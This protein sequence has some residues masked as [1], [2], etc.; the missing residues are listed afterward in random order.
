MKRFDSYLKSIVIAFVA[1]MSFSTLSAQDAFY[2][3]CNDGNF[4]GFFFDRVQRMGVSKLDL[5]GIE[6]E[7]YVV[8]EIQTADSLYRIPLAAIDS[9][10]FQQPEIRYNSDLRHMDE[11]GMSD[12]VTKV[13]G[14]TLTFTNLPSNMRPAVGNVLVGFDEDVFGDSGFG[15]K[16]TRV[17]PQGSTLIVE[18]ERLTDF[19]DIFDQFISVEEVGKDDEGNVRRRLAGFTPDGRLR[20]NNRHPKWDGNYGLSIVDWGGRLQYEHKPND[21]TSISVGV[22][23]GIN[24]GARLVY[25]I[26]ALI[27]RRF[28]VKAVFSEEFSVGVSLQASIGGTLE[29]PIPMPAG[30]NVKI[31][32]PAA[33]PMFQV[34]P[35]PEGFLRA[36]GQFAF[37]LALPKFKKGASQ[38][39][40]ID[41]KASPV[42]D[43]FWEDKDY[44]TADADESWFKQIEAGLTLNGFVQ[45]GVKQNF[46]FETNDWVEDIF[47]A[48][49]GCEVYC[50]PKIEA[51]VNL[52]VDGLLKNGAYG[53]MKDSY[54]EYSKFSLDRELKTK[55][56]TFADH[57][58]SMNEKTFWSDTRKFLTSRWSLFPNF[59]ATTVDYNKDTNLL[60]VTVRPRGQVFWRSW[61]GVGIDDMNGK[62]IQTV[63]NEQQSYDMGNTFNSF[64]AQF[65]DLEPGQYKVQPV[66]RS[67][68]VD[69][70]TYN[71]TTI[72][73]PVIFKNE[74]DSMELD[75]KK[76]N[77]TVKFYTNAK[78]VELVNAFGF[79]P[80]SS[81][82]NTYMIGP[83]AEVRLLTSAI[84]VDFVEN[85]SML[86]NE[87]RIVL[88]GT[89]EAEDV[90]AYDTICFVQDAS[91]LPEYMDI[92]YGIHLYYQ[93]I[94]QRSDYDSDYF[95]PLRFHSADFGIREDVSY[96]NPIFKITCKRERVGYK[97]YRFTW[98]DDQVGH[99]YRSG[100]TG[101]YDN[102][103]WDG[104]M[105]IK[106]H[107]VADIYEDKDS[108]LASFGAGIL[109]IKE[110]Y[111]ERI[112][113]S[114]YNRDNHVL[115]CTHGY[116]HW[117]IWSQ[118]NTGEIRI[119]FGRTKYKGYYMDFGMSQ[120]VVDA[121]N[122]PVGDIDVSYHRSLS[123]KVTTP[124]TCDEDGQILSEEE[125]IEE[126]EVDYNSD[127]KPNLYI[128]LWVAPPYGTD[129]GN[130][131]Q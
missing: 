51:A 9:I 85:G 81:D 80:Y 28:F 18:T 118:K 15:G 49:I 98:D 38:S 36:S 113:N 59:V 110:G 64:S 19:A 16:V 89:N 128:N 67:M 112:W 121:N 55:Y 70:P 25:Q 125:K 129:E 5:D 26:N 62:R 102:W 79:Y 31:K 78:K 42:V 40:I 27:N 34:R 92:S 109:E 82:D 44:P 56:I 21:A 91:G 71:D 35:A 41:S 63:Y 39:I 120:L 114:T 10:V 124:L 54:L 8:Q 106:F 123:E 17:T 75:S 127:N 30:L 84:S 111:F 131:E 93:N 108:E 86:P 122:T 77:K 130:D 65:N 11:L 72:T 20:Q 66:L 48:S 6:H 50:G 100:G 61:V 105:T 46:T 87:I 60:G 1:F 90:V 107:L 13:D 37:G 3:F 45:T 73:I 83:G 103:S 74:V 4:E 69:F 96:D 116:N 7:V 126:D 23:V 94:S 29:K 101:N 57:S 22:D 52:S 47:F 97:H 43:A 115:N 68:G 33:L 88:K 76:Q 117:G 99:N 53:M 119:N 104:N 95:G 2:V 12:Y 14:L 32:F 24:V 58:H